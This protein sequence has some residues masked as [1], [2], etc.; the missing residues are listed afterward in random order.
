MRGLGLEAGGVLGIP[1]KRAS[2]PGATGLQAGAA[3]VDDQDVLGEL[4]GDLLLTHPKPLPGRHHQGDGDNPPGDAEHGEGGSQLVG[5]QGPEG[6]AKE[7]REEHNARRQPSAF[8]YQRSARKRGT[9]AI[10]YQD[11]GRADIGEQRYGS[12]LLVLAP[13]SLLLSLSVHAVAEC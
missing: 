10:S 3:G 1:V 8:S 5:R 4:L 12:R 6:I 11:E 13:C 9:V 2:G 7:V